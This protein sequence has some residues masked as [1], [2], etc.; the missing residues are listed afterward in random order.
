VAPSKPKS[1][2]RTLISIVSVVLVAAMV[3]TLKIVLGGLLG[4]LFHRTTVSDFQVGKCIDQVSL[5]TTAQKT[6]VPNVVDCSSS[7][8]KAKITGVYDGKTA[9]DAT[10][11]CST[12]DAYLELDKSAGG[13]TLVCL[14]SM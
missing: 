8:A 10:T 11:Y 5:S 7:S 13:T 6:S 9:A 2:R 1:G 14:A 12:A 4:G 3:I